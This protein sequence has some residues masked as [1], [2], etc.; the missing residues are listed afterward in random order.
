MLVNGIQ[1][2][3]NA[4]NGHHL[5][6]SWQ[7]VEYAIP[8]ADNQAAVT[9]EFR[10]TADAGLNLGGWNVDDFELGTKVLVPLEAQ[11]TMLPEQV[12]QAGTLTL[13]VKTGT[14]SRP[15]LLGLGDT[16][17][18]LLIPGFPLLLVG[19][20]LGVFSGTTDATGTSVSVFGAP[21]V[22]SAVGQVYYSQVLTLNDTFTQFIASNQH[23]NL[24]TQSP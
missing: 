21:S 3:T 11:L 18:P 14:S 19:G 15:Y 8:M 17:G 13:T 10:L 7:V 22:P 2:W 9:V 16:Q 6:T 5:D 12:V 1:I 23:V 4:L 20:N 24:I